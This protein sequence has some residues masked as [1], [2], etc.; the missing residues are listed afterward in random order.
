[1]SDQDQKPVVRVG[2]V[3]LGGE[4]LDLAMNGRAV[5]ARPARDIYGNAYA[6]R[7]DLADRLCRDL[8]TGSGTVVVPMSVIAIAQELLDQ[9]AACMK[10]RDAALLRLHKTG[11]ERSCPS[12]VLVVLLV[13][14]LLWGGGAQAAVYHPHAGPPSILSEGVPGGER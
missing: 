8:G 9:L 12:F 14:S 1:M 2:H 4:T 6:E 10:E 3:T 13:G 5:L 7:V 11:D